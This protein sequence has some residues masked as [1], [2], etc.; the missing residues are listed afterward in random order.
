MMPTCVAHWCLLMSVSCA[1]AVPDVFSRSQ[2]SRC[3]AA[4]AQKRDCG[5]VGIQPDECSAKGCCWHTSQTSGVP[6][7][8][9]A[10]DYATPPKYKTQ[11]QQRDG[12]RIS[13]DLVL[14]EEGLHQYGPSLPALRIEVSPFPKESQDTL[15]LTITDQADSRWRV[16]PSVL[17]K[18]YAKSKPVRQT[19]GHS[20]TAQRSLQYSMSSDGEPLSFA[21]RRSPSVLQRTASTEPAWP[22]PFPASKARTTRRMVGEPLQF[23]SRRLQANSSNGGASEAARG[24]ADDA[25]FELSSFAF[26]DQYL[27]VATQ[28]PRTSQLLGLAEQSR[29]TGLFL[30]RDGHKIVLWNRDFAAV[31]TDSNL[32]G[33]H[34]L[35]LEL[36]PDGT[37]HGMFVV[38]SNGLE[39]ELAPDRTTFRMVGGMVDIFWLAGPTLEAVVQQYQALVGEPLLPPAWA[40]GFHQSRWGYRSVEELEDTVRAYAAAAIPLDTIWSDIDH[41]DGYRIFT[42]DQRAYAAPRMRAFL[43]RLHAAGR[44]W[45]PIVDPGV[46]VDAGY[47]A[48]DAGLARGLFLRGV[49][50]QPYVGRVWPGAVHFPDFLNPATHSYWEGQLRE[51]HRLA[52]WDGIWIDMNEPSNFCTGDVCSAEDTPEGSTDCGLSCTYDRSQKKYWQPPY[53][54]SNGAGALGERTV[55]MGA[56]HH[57]GAAQWDTHNLYGI[58]ESIATAAAVASITQRRPFVLS[59]S[60]FAGSG[61]VSAHWTGDNAATWQDLRVSITTALLFN[62]MGAPVVGAD[63]CGFMG[64]TTPE[65]C[66]RWISVGSFYTFTRSHSTHDAI[67]Q[68]LY[69]WP[70]VA[71][72]ARNALSLRY[73][74]LPHLYSAL[75]H[76]HACGGT[77]MRPIW[78][79]GGSF[80]VRG[81]SGQHS[82][83]HP[84]TARPFWCATGHL[85]WVSS[86]EPGR[87]SAQPPPGRM[88]RPDEGEID[89]WLWGDGVMVTPVVRQ[90]AR[91]RDVQIPAGQTWLCWR[92]CPQGLS[93]IR[94]RDRRS[95]PGAA[96]ASGAS[97]EDNG[98]MSRQEAMRGRA[99]GGGERGEDVSSQAAQPPDRQAEAQAALTA[100]GPAQVHVAGV[101]LDQVPLWLRFGAIVPMAILQSGQARAAPG[102][103]E[104]AGGEGVESRWGDDAEK[105]AAANA[106]AIDF[107]G[108]LTAEE[109]L[110]QPRQVAVLLAPSDVT[111][112]AAAGDVVTGPDGGA[113]GGTAGGSHLL[114]AGGRHYS[115][116][117]GSLGTHGVHARLF[118][119]H[120]PG[121]GRGF[122]R[123]SVFRGSQAQDT[124]SSAGTDVEPPAVHQIVLWADDS[125]KAGLCQN[126]SSHATGEGDPQPVSQ[127]P[128][129]ASDTPVQDVI[130]GPVSLSASKCVQPGDHGSVVI[131]L[132]CLGCSVHMHLAWDVLWTCEHDV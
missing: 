129:R 84:D 71:R 21:V 51:F 9:I 68:E 126:G 90:G 19:S 60:T 104:R 49:D 35:L 6:W 12:S 120:Y 24:P 66:A 82:R 14:A 29:T 109:T 10:G 57:N 77:V 55:S 33:S 53:A 8:Y 20:P 83:S 27:E 30:P 117:G 61:A 46:K 123:S 98:V 100:S 108:L 81:D 52:T 1:S 96:D 62:A 41:M 26:K 99:G 23:P 2:G 92:G 5:Y 38:S 105:A 101:A 85:N 107:D 59:R 7:C 88:R 58:S 112:A 18:L 103:A 69:R 127:Q 86:A 87:A 37:A 47:P 4:D 31:N 119:I 116:D 40:L 94:S 102:G 124:H 45:V 15:R 78:W 72:A 125:G 73:Q 89:Q 13:A 48:Y 32:Y 43:R 16:P 44:R 28:T 132:P 93:R 65:L 25:L 110:Q 113:A 70:E 131:D 118:A 3:A 95:G 36:R 11:K 17:P 115:D 79:T 34:P 39:A 67:P 76:T 63:I 128:G 111:A 74:L 75:A 80:G 56:T 50:G 54:I 91:E 106:S 114:V 64:S 121:G 97:H 42:L 130:C 122:L 22:S